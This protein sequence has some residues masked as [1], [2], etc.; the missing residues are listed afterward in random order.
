MMD[1]VQDMRPFAHRKALV[2]AYLST[3]VHMGDL[4]FEESE[5]A[6][7]FLAVQSMTADRDLYLLPSAVNM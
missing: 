2:E 3:S 5:I 1:A 6:K 4:T 7:R